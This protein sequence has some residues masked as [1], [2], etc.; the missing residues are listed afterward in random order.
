MTSKS[1]VLPVTV[2]DGVVIIV[3]IAAVV[4]TVVEVVSVLLL[5]LSYQQHKCLCKTLPVK[6]CIIGDCFSKM[7]SNRVSSLRPSGC[8]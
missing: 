4:S 2:E 3:V 5:S 6:A 8:I 1:G 7:K